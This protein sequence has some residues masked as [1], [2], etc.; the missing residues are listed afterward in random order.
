M[1][2][3]NDTQLLSELLDYLGT[4]SGTLDLLVEHLRG[5]AQTVTMD[6]GEATDVAPLDA[7]D[8]ATSALVAKCMEFGSKRV[9][10]DGLE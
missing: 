2:N 7:L 1:E 6:D 3:Q 8:N 9:L 4:F 5:G 10:R